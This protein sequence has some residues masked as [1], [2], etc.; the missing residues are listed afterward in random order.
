MKQTMYSA[1]VGRIESVVRLK[2]D[3][4]GNP[5]YRIIVSSMGNSIVMR[6]TN[7]TSAYLVREGVSGMFTFHTT[8]RG[9]VLD[10]IIYGDIVF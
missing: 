8:Q 7:N 1:I 2:N 10:E 5:R 3:A 6:T 9:N 4:N